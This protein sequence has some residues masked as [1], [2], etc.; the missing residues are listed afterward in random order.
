MLRLRLRKRRVTVVHVAF[1]SSQA[2]A[3]GDLAIP[4][5]ADVSRPSGLV[6]TIWGDGES[7]KRPGDSRKI[8]GPRPVAPE[9]VWRD[10]LG[11]ISMPDFGNL[12]V[13]SMNQ[14][15]ILILY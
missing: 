10:R 12:R 2:D 8:V 14:I 9:M 15:I 6:A 3:S 5:C 11:G 1:R 4:N 13:S 7:G